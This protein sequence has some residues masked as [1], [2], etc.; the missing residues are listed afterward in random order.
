MVRE[1]FVLSGSECLAVLE[2]VAVRQQP[3]GPNSMGRGSS[4][5]GPWSV[6]SHAVTTCRSPTVSRARNR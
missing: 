1:R 3:D 2:Q 4:A 5:N 6:P